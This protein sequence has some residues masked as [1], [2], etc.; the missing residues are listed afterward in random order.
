MAITQEFIEAVNNK[1]IRMVRIMLKDSLVVDPTFV[2]FNK[3]S[4]LA[5][6]N[7]VNLYDEHDGEI[8]KSKAIEWNKD[9]M[10]KQMVQ[11]VYN[12]SRERINLLKDICKYIYR[13]R[14]SRIERERKTYNTKIQISQKQVGAGLVVGSAVATVVGI[15][16]AKPVII[17][18]GIGAA[19]VGGLLIIKDK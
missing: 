4:T 12:F 17:A 9:Y 7:I 18:T 16:I 3:M 6:G 1:D 10:D 8:L 15:S 13:Q 2:E 5:E 11:V 19:V 14:A